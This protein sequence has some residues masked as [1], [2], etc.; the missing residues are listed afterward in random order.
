MDNIV[1]YHKCLCPL[2]WYG[3]YDG[4][5]KYSKYFS[6]QTNAHPAK[7]SFL[8]AEKIFKHLEHL[9]LIHKG[10]RI[11]DFMAG[12]GRTGIVAALNGYK[13]VGIELEPHFIEM[14]EKNRE[15]LKNKMMR[16][17]DWNIIQGDA[18]KLSKLLEEHGAGITS[19]VYGNTDLRYRQNGIV[20]NGKNTTVHIC[21]RPTKDAA[22]V[23]P[24]YSQAQDGGGIF[25]KGYKDIDMVGNRTYAKSTH[26][27][28]E[29][30]IGNLK[31][32]AIVSPPYENMDVDGARKMI[33]GYFNK[34]GGIGHAKTDGVQ[35]DNSENIGSKQSQTY[36]EAMYK[37]YLEAY[38]AGISPLVVVTKNPTRN[39]KLRRLDIDTARLLEMVGYKIIDYHQA[40]LWHWVEQKQLDGSVKRI[41]KGRLSFFKRLS[42]KNGNVAAD[43]EDI[44]FVVKL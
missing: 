36:L 13:F 5:G 29:D 20:I 39:H 14:I 4:N 16:D 41:P 9:G 34:I 12:T 27:F 33:E 30:Q 1:N 42:L 40:V 11:I 26:N 18:R 22:I 6:P 35:Q 7:M 19:P 21:T 24:P 3:L 43:H 28:T 25:R 10:D 15:V 31:D 37:V 8:L 32:A 2:K 23:S 17:P 38:K 44:L